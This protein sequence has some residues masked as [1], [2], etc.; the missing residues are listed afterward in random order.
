MYISACIRDKSGKAV[1]WDLTELDGQIGMAY[2]LPQYR[3]LKLFWAA[4][5]VGLL[6]LEK[7]D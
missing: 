6:S 4:G 3:R 2:T 1:S 7:I 5:G